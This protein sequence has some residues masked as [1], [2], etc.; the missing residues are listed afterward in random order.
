MKM[1]YI[2]IIRVIKKIKFPMRY[3]LREVRIVIIKKSTNSKCR[4]GFERNPITLMVGIK[5]D[6]TTAENRMEVP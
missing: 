2:L 1:L 3:K 6:I 4:T 5:I